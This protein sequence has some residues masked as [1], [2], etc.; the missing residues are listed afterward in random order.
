MQ[1]TIDLAKSSNTLNKLTFVLLYATDFADRL[2]KEIIPALKAGFI[3]LADRY[4]YTAM[5]RAG[6][7]RRRSRVDPATCTASRSRPHLVFYLKIDV[8]TLIRRVLQSRGMDYWESG[9]DLK[10]GDDIYDSFRAYQRALLREYASMADEFGFRV[11][12]ARRKV[13]VIQDELRRQIGAFLAEN[14]ASAVAKSAK[15]SRRP[16][17]SDAT[18]GVY[19]KFTPAKSAGNCRRDSLVGL[20]MTLLQTHAARR[21]A[22]AGP[23]AERRDAPT[24][25]SRSTSTQLN[26]FYGAKRAL[27]DISHRRSSRHL[28]TAF[29]GPSGCGKSTFLRTLNRMNDI[30]AGTRVEGKVADRRARHL[31]ARGPTSSRS[32][33]ASAWCSRSR[34]RFRSRSSRTSP[35]ACAS[36]AWRAAART[37]TSG[38]RRACKSA[39]IWDEVKDRLHDSALA[40]SGGQQQRLCI[41]RAL[42]VKPEILLMDEPASAL[43]PIATQRIEELIYQLKRATPS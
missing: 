29:I 24:C 43:D 41:A 11:L 10:L 13:D 18:G 27:E 17:C 4:I 39:A 7:A 9:M 6:R 20:A 1:P 28:V 23:A 34:T 2:E 14:D 5:A 19:A 8:K 37:C 15:P 16:P 35:T 21:S 40:L 32:A 42:A 30:I 33:A 36:T 3:V 38:S 26:F 22:V 12:D 25:R 31:R